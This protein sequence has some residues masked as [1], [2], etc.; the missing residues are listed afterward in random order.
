MNI[1]SRITS[2]GVPGIIRVDE[3]TYR[4][5][6]GSLQ[7]PRPPDDLP[8]GERQYGHY[9]RLIG[10]KA[11]AVAVARPVRR[12]SGTISNRIVADRIRY[13]AQQ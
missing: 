5:L 4:R 6:Q 13:Q 3:T 8:E 12:P 1:A 11:P 9:A 7:L 2:E 10:P